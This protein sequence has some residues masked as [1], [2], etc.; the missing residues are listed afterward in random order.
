MQLTRSANGH[1]APGNTGGP[2]NPHAR[3]TAHIKRVLL[4]AI[5]DDDLRAIIKSLI[6]QAKAGNAKAAELILNRLVGK[7]T[8]EPLSG[9]AAPELT[10]EQEAEFLAHR[11]A[12]LLGRFQCDDRPLAELEVTG[13]ISQTQR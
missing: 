2:G 6:E 7:P 10:Q 3:R 5:T 13:E 4:D 1:F 12:E 9:E 8:A 11:R